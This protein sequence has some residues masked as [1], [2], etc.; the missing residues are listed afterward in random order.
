[1]RTWGKSRPDRGN[2]RGK[3]PKVGAGIEH[4]GDGEKGND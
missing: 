2:S 3:G 4:S 1:M